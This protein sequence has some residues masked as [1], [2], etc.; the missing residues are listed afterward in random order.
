MKEEGFMVHTPTGKGSSIRGSPGLNPKRM[1]SL[2][3]KSIDSIESDKS[4]NN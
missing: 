2:N 4:P 3:S 1:L